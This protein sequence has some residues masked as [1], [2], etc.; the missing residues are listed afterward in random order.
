MSKQ[1]FPLK[2]RLVVEAI[3]KAFHSLKKNKYV[4]NAHETN[5]YEINKE[6]PHYCCSSS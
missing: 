3:E 4:L 6:K 5:P 1:P 2:N